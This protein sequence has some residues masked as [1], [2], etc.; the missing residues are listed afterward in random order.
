MSVGLC[1]KGIAMIERTM[2]QFLWGFSEPGK[3]KTP[4]IAWR[5]LH[6]PKELGGLGWTGLQQRM[7]AQLSSKLL[8]CLQSNGEMV[9]WQRKLERKRN[10]L[11]MLIH[12]NSSRQLTTYNNLEELLELATADWSMRIPILCI[13]AHWIALVWQDRNHHQ[14]S[15]VRTC[16]PLKII[17][18]R[19]LD[20]T[21]AMRRSM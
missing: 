5:K 21:N 9:N 6:Y 18:N 1:A 7:A 15:N 13:V 20:E 2:R 10:Q 3:P 11:T 8:R 16:A 14:F 12:Q 17:I 4:L 19:A